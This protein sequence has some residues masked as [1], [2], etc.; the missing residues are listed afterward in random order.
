MDPGTYVELDGRPAVRF[1]RTYPHPAER[2]WLAVSTP[3]GLAH[4]FPAQVA[5]E[6]RA[7]R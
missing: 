7:H 4:W 6:L 3:E 2:V 1:V 5:L